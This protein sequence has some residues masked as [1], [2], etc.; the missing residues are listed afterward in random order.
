MGADNAGTPHTSHPPPLG[1]EGI[2]S[3]LLYHSSHTYEQWV[4]GKH[5]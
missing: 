4:G 1:R 2:Y 5:T 3:H